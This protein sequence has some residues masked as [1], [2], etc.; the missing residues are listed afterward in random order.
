MSKPIIGIACS[1]SDGRINMGNT[2]L[3]AIY[4]AGG[5][6]VYLPL[7]DDPD[8]FR[9]VANDFDGFLYSGGVDL[10]PER[11][12]ESVTAQNV[13]I[14][15]ARDAYELALFNEIYKTGKPILGICRGIQTLN[16]ALGGTLLQDIPNH[17]QG[18]LG[19]TH[20]D[21]PQ[22]VTLVRNS[23]LYNI[24][25]VEKFKVNSWHHQAVKDLAPTLEIDARSDDGIIEAVHSTEHPFLLGIQWH[26]E[27]LQANDKNAA[28]I[29][30]AFVDAC[31]K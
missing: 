14:D 22:N 15:D 18:D 5:I 25:G 1:Y 27:I 24:I 31:K 12:G 4:A 30:K 23:M 10:N 13:E 21:A 2:Y 7:T 11:Y 17:R 19:Y 28:A 26:P 8:F 9:S 29:F 20:K 3:F 6:P 16:V